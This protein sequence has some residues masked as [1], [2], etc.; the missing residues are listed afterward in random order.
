MKKILLM[1]S[2]AFFLLLAACNQT[3][4]NELS[5]QGG[6][7]GQLRFNVVS[8]YRDGAEE[9]NFNGQFDEGEFLVPGMQISLKPI[10]EKGEVIGEPFSFLTNQAKDPREGAMLK[11]PVGIYQPELVLPTE[12]Q[13]GKEYAWKPFGPPL[14]ELP[15][16]IVKYKDLFDGIYSVGCE[17]GGRQYIQISGFEEYQ[18]SP[19]FSSPPEVQ[20]SISVSDQ[21]LEFPCNSLQIQT[22]VNVHYAPSKLNIHNPVTLSVDP[23][24]LPAG[25]TVSFSPNP[26]ST[27]STLTLTANGV[28]AGSYQII[29]QD[30][31]GYT[32]T[33]TVN[34][35]TVIP[36]A[37]LETAI[38]TTL[39]I[40]Q[41]HEI[42]KGDMLLL[43]ELVVFNSSIDS[44][45]G[46]QYATNLEY[47]YFNSY[48]QTNL[49]S[50]LR[51]LSGLTKLNQIDLSYNHIS[52]LRP[53]SGLTNLLALHLSGNSISDLRPLS[54]L[55]KLQS[56]SFRENS[57]SDLSPLSSLTNL[58]G[59]FLDNNLISDLT[60]LSSLTNLTSLSLERN[61]ISNLTPLSNLTNLTSLLLG[62][63][64][65]SDL[66]PLSSLTNLTT[67]AA[68]YNSISDLTPL[69]S[70]RLMYLY[71]DNNLISDITAL[72]N[73]Q[74]LGSGGEINLKFNL[75][76]LSG[77]PDPDLANIQMLQ[78]RG[79]TV[80]Y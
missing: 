45:E 22:T 43:T 60:P 53:L 41:S 73:N 39:N 50:D 63:N 10:N 16:I 64:S 48:G 11:V 55:T 20:D 65:I 25:M 54:G 79:V 1:V 66:A 8:D 21:S 19:C 35:A 70:L 49:I 57:I 77:S 30:S 38:K 56:L 44:L 5:T 31:R 6:D 37:N 80:Y 71:F 9:T 33:L 78:N 29:I 4:K 26:T 3:P 69:L 61:S 7:Y 52:D 75:L 2:L 58:G 24:S 40:P 47:L 68:S 59:L 36:D 72:V 32:T 12:L 34:V 76:D 51:P 27:Q 28:A 46:L 15:P 62:R 42:C 67:L 14:P 23:N 13:G 17:Y 74:S 18:L